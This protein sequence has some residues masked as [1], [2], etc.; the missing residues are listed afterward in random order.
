V[1]PPCAVCGTPSAR[2]ELVA[3][4]ACPSSG[5][6]GPHRAGQH[7]EQRQPDSGTCCSRRRCGNG[8][9]DPIDASRPA[10]RPGV[11]VSCVLRPGPPRRLH[12]DAGFCQA[13][14]PVLLPALERIG[15]GYGHCL[16]PCKS[17]INT[18]RHRVNRY[19]TLRITTTWPDGYTPVITSLTGCPPI[20]LNGCT[21]S[22]TSENT[23]GAGRPGRH[24][25]IRQDHPTDQER[26]DIKA[27]PS[28]CESIS[29]QAGTHRLLL[30]F[31]ILVVAG[32]HG[33]VVV[34]RVA[35]NN[36]EAP[37]IEQSTKTTLT[38]RGF[39]AFYRAAL[40]LSSK[41]LNYAARSSAAPRLDRV[42]VRKLNP[43]SRRSSSWSTCVKRDVRR[44]AAGFGVGTATP[45]V[46]E[47]D[48]GAARGPAPKLRKAVRTRR[49]RVR[50]RGPGRHLIPV[51]RVARTVRSTPQAPR[52]GMNL[53]V[54][55]A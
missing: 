45:G 20:K 2:V 8:Y 15:G 5:T 44:G 39:S 25:C 50:L 30:S 36:E 42:A 34:R 12:D 52:H 49:R 37:V 29:A 6:S 48:G 9:G 16:A 7:R 18:G 31:F 1:T 22:S 24:A 21:T 3:L 53:Q 23:S 11:P 17:L 10:D 40:P 35:V 41:T 32:C 38:T 47:R 28:R 4:D 19:M 46:R 54:I 33:L 26:G 55:A 13:A 43:A 27:W 51:D 14:T